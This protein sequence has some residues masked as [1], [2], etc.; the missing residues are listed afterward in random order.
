MMKFNGIGCSPGLAFGKAYKLSLEDNLEPIPDSSIVV[1]E[2]S[3]PQ[4]ILSLKN[5]QGIICE[6][7]GNMS[8]LAILCREIGKPC[9]TG[10]DHIYSIIQNGDGIF[11]NGRT[12][13]V[14]INE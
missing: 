12:G 14:L 8:H 9:V 4:W 2:R 10:I 1:V 3:S 7:G 6:L 11:I 13:E 5:A